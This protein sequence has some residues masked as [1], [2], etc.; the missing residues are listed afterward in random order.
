FQRSW[1]TSFFQVV[2]LSGCRVVKL[3]KFIVET[4]SSW[5]TVS[6]NPAINV[7]RGQKQH[8]HGVSWRLPWP[9]APS[10][11]GAAERRGTEPLP[12]GDLSMARQVTFAP[13]RIPDRSEY[14]PHDASNQTA[15]WEQGHGLAPSARHGRVQ[16]SWRETG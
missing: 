6:M 12:P 7:S 5:P 14:R 1:F 10:T 8:D 15:K 4:G 11:N 9:I 3:S 13:F 2:K 16:A